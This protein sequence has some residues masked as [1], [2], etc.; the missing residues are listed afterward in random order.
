LYS[1]VQ[2]LNRREQVSFSVSRA[3]EGLDMQSKEHKIESKRI[4]GS[5]IFA[6]TVFMIRAVDWGASLTGDWEWNAQRFGTILAFALATFVVA[7]L[8]NHLLSRLGVGDRVRYAAW[9]CALVGPYVG[10]AGSDTPES[11]A[12]QIIGSTFAIL[13]FGLG[14]WL[15]KR[16]DKRKPVGSRSTDD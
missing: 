9:L 7:F 10:A 12:N 11:A 3:N 6:S 5:L 13:T 14:F 1:W 4:Q 2:R 16:R 8:I 15:A